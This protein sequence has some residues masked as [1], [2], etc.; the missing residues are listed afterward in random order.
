[1]L[2]KIQCL[3]Y[4]PVLQEHGLS[5]EYRSQFEDETNRN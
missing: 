5:K 2:I 4:T 3:S 1:M